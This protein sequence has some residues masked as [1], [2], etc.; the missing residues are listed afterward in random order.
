MF[1]GKLI[2]ELWYSVKFFT[3]CQNEASYKIWK[4]MQEIQITIIMLS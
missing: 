3:L 1:F 2:N 4:E